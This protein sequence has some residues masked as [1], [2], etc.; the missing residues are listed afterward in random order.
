MVAVSCVE[1]PD[2]L[3]EPE[4][5]ITSPLQMTIPAEGGTFEITYTLTNPQED[6][7]IYL[8]ADK[9]I[10]NIDYT[11]NGKVIFTVSENE[12]SISRSTLAAL[13]Y[14]YGSMKIE[15]SINI[16]QDSSIPADYK[17]INTEAEMEAF[18]GFGLNGEDYLVL[19]FTGT[20]AN[21]GGMVKS[22]NYNFDMYAP[23]NE[24]Y[25]YFYNIPEGTY[26]IGE[27]GQTAPMSLSV[28]NCY[29]YGTDENDEIVYEASFSEGTLTVTPNKDGTYV[30]RA[31]LTDINGKTHDIRYSGDGK[32]VNKDIPESGYFPLE[33]DIDLTGKVSKVE[34]VYRDG[35]SSWMGHNMN[36]LFRFTDAEFDEG[37]GEYILPGNF[38]YVDVNMPYDKDGRITPGTYDI[39]VGNN[40]EQAT[41]LSIWGGA[42]ELIMMFGSY[43]EVFIGTYAQYVSLDTW[44]SPTGFI[45]KGSL[46]ITE[47]A[48]G[49]SFEGD[50]TTDEGR[51]VKFTYTGDVS[52]L[53]VPEITP[54]TSL[55]GDYELQLGGETETTAISYYAQK[56]EYTIGDKENGDYI[57]GA[58]WCVEPESFENGI[59][60][61]VYKDSY[62]YASP[63]NPL[64]YYRGFL[65][66]WGE[67]VGT[68]FSKYENGIEI[69]AAPLNH[70]S[71]SIKRIEGDTYEFTFDAI[72]D[73][74]NKITG[75]WTGEIKIEKAPE[76]P[77]FASQGTSTH[78]TAVPQLNER[79]PL[80][81][82]NH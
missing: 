27:S 62:L 74:F 50:F 18:P 75:T 64:A 26:S 82:L 72:D 14:S 68:W 21:E 22:L 67:R 13:S 12:E 38:I 71:I 79:Y 45:N 34:A 69:E 20:Q 8:T 41:D 30:I 24:K 63:D 6:G 48:G 47:N 35:Y 46:T 5:E 51:S 80:Q 60:E 7:K 61:G 2:T 3:A 81:R 42:G 1:K 15:K 59:I 52:V 33:E 73:A 10:E 25:E 17:C 29:V 57:S 44:Y 49:Y 43:Q 28:D 54:S 23:H 58:L 31:G 77:Q 4:L 78:R 19:M 11:N 32:C 53:Y 56:I 37:N 76:A 70:G 40:D 39:F 36:V 66:G 9:W 55:E 65:D 16:I